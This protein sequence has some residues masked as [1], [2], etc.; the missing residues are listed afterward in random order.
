MIN[1]RGDM[2]ICREFYD[3]ETS[4]LSVWDL[5]KG[6]LQSIKEDPDPSMAGFA[7]TT[8]YRTVSITTTVN[9]IE[10][11]SVGE[12]RLLATLNNYGGQWIAYTPDGFFDGS[13]AAWPL[14]SLRS[15]DQPRVLLPI[16]Q[17]LRDRYLPGLLS[18][19][20]R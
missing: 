6:V 7:D 9:G 8:N 11:W 15:V 20:T 18:L 10:L 19:I 12:R 5:K 17:Y 13:P 3:E 4:Q 1:D 16:E 14:I 2:L